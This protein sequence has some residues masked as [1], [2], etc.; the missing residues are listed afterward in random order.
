VT[1]GRRVPA[2]LARDLA[3][4]RAGGWEAVELW[5]DHWDAHFPPHADAAAR[6]VLDGSGLAVAGACAQEGLFFARGEERR[7]R[8]SEFS[9][10]LERCAALGVAHLVV[11]PVPP[12]EDEPPAEEELDRAAEHLR[13]AGELALATG[14]GLEI[15]F[16]GGV[17][18]VN[19]LATALDLASRV[20]H[21]GVGVLLDTYHL[22]AGPSKLEDLD[23]LAAHPGRLRFVHVND[24]P[25]ARPRELWTDADRVLPGDGDLP[26]A[27]VLGAIRRSGYAGD[28]SLELFNAEFAARWNEDPFRAAAEAH[29]SVSRLLEA[30]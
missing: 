14:V 24:V 19:N 27:R 30:A 26:L 11:V 25:A 8:A 12:P 22:Y 23:L 18:L 15:E 7:R 1:A 21:A 28:V 9:R 29:R 5:L 20:D 17:R 4:V 13:T 10:R 3:A 16:L 2:D 6:R